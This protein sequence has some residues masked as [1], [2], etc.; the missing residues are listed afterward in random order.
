MI[1]RWLS[2]SAIALRLMLLRMRSESRLLLL[3][4][5]GS[6]P[7]LSMTPDGCWRCG[8]S[9]S[10][11]GLIMSAESLWWGWIAVVSW[12]RMV[13]VVRRYVYCFIRLDIGSRGD[14][15]ECV[16]DCWDLTRQY[17][18]LWVGSCVADEGD[19]PR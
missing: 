17:I 18:I 7:F 5:H 14:N 16:D 11:E 2:S 12:S 3:T 13:L 8:W 1:T 4:L 15:V 9:I 10:L 19:K 6:I